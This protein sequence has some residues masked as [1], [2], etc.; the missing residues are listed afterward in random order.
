MIGDSI[1]IPID[2]KILETT[3]SM[4]KKGD[5]NQKANTESRS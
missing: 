1:I 5:K 2:I 3:R 4:I